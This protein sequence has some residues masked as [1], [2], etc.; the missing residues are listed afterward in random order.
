MIQ[1][2]AKYIVLV[3]PGESVQSS[4]LLPHSKNI[5]RKLRKDIECSRRLT[6]TPRSANETSAIEPF[7]DDHI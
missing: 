6:R 4:L 1:V 3:P 7:V 2:P 5:A